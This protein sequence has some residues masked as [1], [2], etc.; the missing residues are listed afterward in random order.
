[1]M[2]EAV[3]AVVIDAGIRRDDFKKPDRECVVGVM[4]DALVEFDMS[5]HRMR[6]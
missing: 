2:R 1:M 6:P 3:R 4:Q 5:M